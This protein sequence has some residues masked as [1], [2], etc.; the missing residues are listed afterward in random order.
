MRTVAHQHRPFS[1]ILKPSPRNTAPVLALALALAAAALTIEK[2]SPDAVMLAP[3]RPTICFCIAIFANAIASPQNLA[4][5]APL[6]PSE[7][8]KYPKTRYGYIESSEAFD[9]IGAHRF[10]HFV[11]KPDASTAAKLVA[12][13]LLWNSGIYIT[14]PRIILRNSTACAPTSWPRPSKC[15]MMPILR[16]LIPPNAKY[17]IKNGKNRYS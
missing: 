6:P 8:P 7:C 2:Q 11:E 10:K 12:S 4:A 13:G 16:P 15:G 9:A 5:W 17:R 3:P 14:L 1:I